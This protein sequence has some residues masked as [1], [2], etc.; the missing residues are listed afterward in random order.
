VDLF[1]DAEYEDLVSLA[2]Y[3]GEQK[4]FFYTNAH[5]VVL[6][7]SEFPLLKD[8]FRNKADY[9][10]CDGAGIQL[11]ARL[12]SKSIPVKTAYNVWFWGFARFC[13]TKKFKLFF[14]GARDGV[15]ER[16][17]QNVIT[18]APGL[19]IG[20]HHGYFIKEK[21][22]RDNADVIQLINEYD[23]DILLVGFGAPLQEN[24]IVEN[25]DDLNARA[26]FSCGGAFEYFAGERKVA[27]GWL[28][29]LKLEW[30]YRMTEEP[31]RLGKRYLKENPMFLYY[32]FKN[33]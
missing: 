3:H 27:P 28:R 16:A 15:I 14:L 25:K 22:H 31:W 1:S 6:A 20:T 7:N 19:Q 29:K 24:W 11:G 17:A 21:E 13:E 30:L 12:K 2:V 33:D 23:P 10:M 8:A 4:I 32:V 5:L 9:V 18:H 26:I